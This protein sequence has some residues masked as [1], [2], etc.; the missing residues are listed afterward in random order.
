VTQTL[1]YIVNK[2]IVKNGYL[3]LY[4]KGKKR[5]DISKKKFLIK[6]GGQK[7]YTK[8]NHQGLAII[9]V[10]V[11]SGTYNILAKHGK[12][13]II[14]KINCIEDYV[15]NPLENN[16]SLVNGAPDLDYMPANYVMADTKATYTI[17]RTQYLEVI[18]RDSYCLFLNN[19]LSRYVL[20]RTASRPHTYHIIKREKWNVIEKAINKKLVSKNKYRYWPKKIK[21]SLKG[22]S[23]KYSEVRDVQNKG[24]TCGPTSASVCSQVLR[25]Y[26]PEG[27]LSKRSHTTRSGTK[28]QNL[29]K[30]LYKHNFKCTHFYKNSFNTALTE[31]KKGGCA[32]IFHSQHHYVT[33]IDI[34]KN[35]KRVLVSNS[36]G[37]YN[38]IPS[39]WISTYYMRHKFGVWDDSLIVRLNYNLNNST[40]NSI[41]CFYNSM[42]KN[43]NRHNLREKI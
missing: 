20:F 30:V 6:I 14:K 18:K 21:I 41:N 40:K 17:T 34:S 15:K 35:G 4:L 38:K 13:H 23:Y 10:N 12:Y 29:E 42:G 8:T 37:N 25:N 16:I 22:K 19:K 33:I 27:Y 39:K 5:S 11:P 24:Y 7:Y 43:W 3:R 26:I 28:I 36:Y 2:K 1:F 31:L 32:V 9:K